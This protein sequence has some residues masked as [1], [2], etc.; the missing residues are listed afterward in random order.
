MEKRSDTFSFLI[1][2]YFFIFSKRTHNFNPC[3]SCWVDQM[4]QFIH[5][6]LCHLLGELRKPQGHW[7]IKKVIMH[8]LMPNIC[9][10]IPRRSLLT[11][12]SSPAGAHRARRSV[13]GY[14]LLEHQSKMT[15][16]TGVKRT[17][18]GIYYDSLSHTHTK[19]KRTHMSVHFKK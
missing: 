7:E 11:L 9:S 14:R 2:I 1:R 8:P 4:G 3:G 19:F 18:T 17:K 13:N 10:L 16:R 6:A 12:W 15:L 5:P